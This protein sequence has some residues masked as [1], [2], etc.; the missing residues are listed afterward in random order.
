M[1]PATIQ[2]IEKNVLKLKLEL[3]KPDVVI[4]EKMGQE[5]D[6]TSKTLLD[7]RTSCHT[8]LS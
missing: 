8:S 1:Y 4:I 7:L 5:I 2:F 6:K 3:K